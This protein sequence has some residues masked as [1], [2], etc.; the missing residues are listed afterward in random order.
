MNTF[1]CINNQKIISKSDL[2]AELSVESQN[3][4]IS[5]ILIQSSLLETHHRHFTYMKM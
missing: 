2:S 5:T 4:L 3:V 1:K